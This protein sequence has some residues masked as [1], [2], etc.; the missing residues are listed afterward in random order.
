MAGMFH[1]TSVQIIDCMT[2]SDPNVSWASE[3]PWRVSA[4][5][6]VVANV[7]SGGDVDGGGCAWV[8]TQDTW[9]ISAPSPHFGCNPQTALKLASF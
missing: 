8:E 6:S 2:Q 4:G 7:P 1:D 9:E 5:S 3:R